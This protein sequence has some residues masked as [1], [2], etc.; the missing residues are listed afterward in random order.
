M[1]TGHS[2][3]LCIA[4]VLASASLVLG[5]SC[6]QDWSAVTSAQLS[7]LDPLCFASARAA[8]LRALPGPS[9]AG[10]DSA[11]VAQLESTVAGI[12]ACGGLSP[13]C[14]SVLPASAAPGIRK[15]CMS[16]L[17]PAFLGSLAGSA[18][19]QIPADSFAGLAKSSVA[20]LGAAC[21]NLGSAQVS[22]I[23][24]TLNNNDACAGISAA[25]TSSLSAAA[26]A[27]LRANCLAQLSVGAVSGL[28]REQVAAI[29]AQ[30]WAG[31]TRDNVAGLT[32]A[33]DGVGA[34]QF[35]MLGVSMNRADTCA[36]LQRSCAE[37]LSSASLS[38][39]TAA[40]MRQVSKAFVA[41]LSGAAVSG[42]NATAFSGFNDNI[43][44]LGT[45]CGGLVADQVAMIGRSFLSPD[46]CSFLSATCGNSTPA[47][48]MARVTAAC[49][50]HL[51]SGF[52]AALTSAHLREMP[53][54][55]FAGWTRENIAPLAA[56]CSGITA[57]QA[58]ALGTS[59]ASTD[60][61][62][63]MTALCAASLMPGA[64]SGLRS[65]CVLFLTPKYVAALSAE[66]LS[67]IPVSACAGFT[68]GNLAELGPTCA[69]F[70][71][72][73]ASRI[74]SSARSIDA[75]AGFGGSCAHFF[76]LP[77]LGGIKATCVSHLTA[78]FVSEL[79]AQQ[80][81]AIP[82]MSVAGFTSENIGG[83]K[84]SC[85]GLGSNQTRFL[86]KR[87]PPCRKLEL[88]CLRS[89]S[90]VAFGGFELS[91]T[92]EW[93]AEQALAATL[94]KI[95][96][97]SSDGH[98]GLSAVVWVALV[99]KHGESLV[100]GLTSDSMS[101][102]NLQTTQAFGR[103]VGNGTVA[104]I[105]KLCSQLSRNATP[106]WLQMSLSADNDAQCIGKEMFGNM[107]SGYP[108]VR[109]GHLPHIAAQA[110]GYVRTMKFFTNDV[111]RA[112]S[113]EQVAA[114]PFAVFGGLQERALLLSESAASGITV[115]QMENLR[116][117]GRWSCPQVRS[118]GHDVQQALVC[119]EPDKKYSES[120]KVDGCS[121]KPPAS[122]DE[123]ARSHVSHP[124]QET[125]S[126]GSLA[127]LGARAE[128]SVAVLC[129]LLPRYL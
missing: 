64:A 6:P 85:S 37:H 62:G 51:S 68:A 18:I 104:P 103:L 59:I 91:C 67:S 101:L 98:G 65:Q 124:T 48:A 77:G 8:D 72:A 88:D 94:E 21:A 123:S 109:P 47:A 87:E 52:V 121:S 111:V 7:A 53:A 55:S 76:S 4:A 113:A 66:A 3:F 71:G 82:A 12:G 25:C 39:A 50:S 15:N 17:S 19:G 69:A 61:C 28:G 2:R 97:M 45:A 92:F 96:A 23:G 20:A 16:S 86:G 100:E 95:L 78:R 40:C 35:A 1:Y 57:E 32:S 22:A 102:I 115:S 128:F 46:A 24:S 9:C 119:N 125:S 34:D 42:L 126:A 80:V 116:T 30:S 26:A 13:A 44:A 33:C 14:A 114:I 81:S 110:F 49:V 31:W 90:V 89:A 54:Q 38:R 5:A 29:P 70:T 79:S 56:A 112:L 75:C 106:H 73:Q 117:T 105:H 43:G 36:G 74:G 83:L 60:A 63:G 99:E 84:T 118:M 41:G 93:R 11:R 107:K 122:H 108:G 127:I 10:F 27:G 58:S 129:A 120:C